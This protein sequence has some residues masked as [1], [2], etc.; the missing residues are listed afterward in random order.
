[1]TKI[2]ERANTVTQYAKLTTTNNKLSVITVPSGNLLICKNNAH[3]VALSWSQFQLLKSKVK[4]IKQL[5]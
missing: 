1:M 4:D 3:H 5:V 2:H